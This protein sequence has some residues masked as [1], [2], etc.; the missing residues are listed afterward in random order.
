MIVNVSE[1]IASAFRLHPSVFHFL[2]RPSPVTGQLWGHDVNVQEIFQFDVSL[3]QQTIAAGGN[4]ITCD[5]TSPLI[6]KPSSRFKWGR[7]PTTM[8]GFSVASSSALAIAGSSCGNRPES[9][10]TP[11]L[12]RRA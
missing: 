11:K 10:C 6:N 9:C 1:A 12:G 5:S 8:I 7:W 3:L 4:S 2:F